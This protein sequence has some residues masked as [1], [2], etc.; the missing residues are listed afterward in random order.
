MAPRP[1][2]PDAVARATTRT[3]LIATIAVAVLELFFVTLPWLG[4]H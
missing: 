3:I 4:Y 2:E 1:G